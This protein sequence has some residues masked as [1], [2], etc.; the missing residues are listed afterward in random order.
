MRVSKEDEKQKE[1]G[2]ITN[3]RTLIHTF[4][5]RT[6]EFKQYAVY[7]YW[8]DGYSGQN[9]E[10]PGIK[11]LLLEV[12][13]NKVS[14]I[15]VKDF[16][17]FSRDYIEMGDYLE[18]IFP[19]MGI[20]F[21]S[22]NDNYDSIKGRGLIPEIGT[23]FKT[24]LYDFYSKD[25][26][27][28]VKNSIAEK[29]EKG[30]YPFG[31]IPFG[32]R[33]DPDKKNRV[34]INKKEAEIVTYIFE[35]AALG[36]SSVQI[37]KQLHR[38]NVPTCGQ[39][40]NPENIST[41]RVLCWN[42]LRIREIL[43][44]P[45]Y[46][47]I[48]DCNQT[49]FEEHHMPVISREIFEKINKNRKMGHSTK[50]KYTKHPLTGILYC[51]GC[52]YSMSYKRDGKRQK[53]K[54]FECR[55]HSTLNIPECCTYLRADKLEKIVL[56]ALHREIQKLADTKLFF[57]QLKG[58]LEARRQK[59]IK[60]IENCRKELKRLDLLKQNR[61]EVFA[62]TGKTM[63]EY[64]QSIEGFQVEYLKL[65]QMEKK[66]SVSN[67]FCLN[68]PKNIKSM[69]YYAEALELTQ[70]VVDTFINRIKVY[71]GGRVEIEWKFNMSLD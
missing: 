64:Q 8:D 70:A 1:S 29:C 13:K 3:Q 67:D 57:E 25:I 9:F 47:G 7:D 55:M 30:I 11:K 63:V 42:S 71:R 20:R 24:L 14:C 35:L 6:N 66:L 53:Y 2:S 23:A 33:K 34:Q 40:R 38:E 10:R 32:Y 27:M 59:Q 31:Q 39:I 26:S 48:W 21:I 52:N 5:N 19:F 68:E 62:E 45:F 65:K 61:Y 46:T 56:S 4:I 54:R 15:I 12:K 41:D 18:R 60:S 49:Y 50:R 28:K 22:I 37:A 51:G 43:C 16:S 36:F 58:V 17:R 69:I 44:N